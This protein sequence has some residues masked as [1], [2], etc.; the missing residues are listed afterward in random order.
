MLD[1]PVYGKI[2]DIKVPIL[3]IYGKGDMLIP[4]K[5][6]HPQLSLDTLLEKLKTDYPKIKTKQLEEAGHFVLWDQSDA[7]NNCILEGF[8]NQ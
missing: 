1:E 7:V 2:A 5:I 6:L 3:V 4:N 8:G